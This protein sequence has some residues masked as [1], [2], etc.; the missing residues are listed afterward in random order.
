[1]GKWKIRKQISGGADAH[2]FTV[3]YGEPGAKQNYDDYSQR[4]I[5][6]RSR[7]D[8]EIGG[9]GDGGDGDEEEEEDDEYKDESEGILAFIDPPDLN[10]P[11]DHNKDGICEVVL[12]YV[13]TE[14]GD[15]NVPIPDTPVNLVISDTTSLDIAVLKT[16]QTPIEEVDPDLIQSDTDA[17]GVVNSIDEDDDGDGID[18]RF[19]AAKV[20]IFSSRRE[21]EEG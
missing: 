12:G 16:T 14:M 4:T 8:D 10:D 20:N 15:T 18:S 21:I 7:D 17:D 11:Q 1:M 3:K 13:N 2:L 19:E 6:N 5:I 9:N